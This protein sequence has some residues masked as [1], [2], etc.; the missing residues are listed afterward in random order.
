MGKREKKG[1]GVTILL[2]ILK[3]TRKTSNYNDLLRRECICYDICMDILGY[4]LHVLHTYR[5]A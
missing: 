1:A 2:S 3:I 5:L 4:H